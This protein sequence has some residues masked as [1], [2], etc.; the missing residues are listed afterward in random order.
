MQ[1]AGV[2]IRDTLAAH[3][4]R[5]Q[6]AGICKGPMID[7]NALLESVLDSLPDGLAVLD[8]RDSV[9]FWNAEAE[10]ITGYV[11]SEIQTSKQLPGLARLLERSQQNASSG[12]PSSAT[13]V[14]AR[15]KL[16]HEVLV[17]VRSVE[18][19]NVEGAVLGTAVLFHPSQRLDEL[20]CGET[21]DEA[22]IATGQAEFK[23][24]L[25]AEFDDFERGEQSFGILWISVD[26]GYDL[27]RTH[28]VAACHAML[29]K[30]QHAIASGLRPAETLARWGEDEFLVLGHERSA[31]ML[32]RHACTLAGLA[33]TADFRWW[34]DRVS[35]TVSIGAAQA[36]FKQPL[37][38]LLEQARTAMEAS[39]RVGGNRVT[40]APSEPDGN[41]SD[42]EESICTPS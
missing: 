9:T 7:R 2:Q 5:I 25:Y 10:A 20:L 33:R 12:Q 23:E 13:L 37:N 30:V 34:G 24:R 39:M 6:A 11:R 28:G 3:Y 35:L 19:R 1:S 31:E 42:G 32:A 38:N 8:G 17:I 16:G 18:L 26:Q 4:A 41:L 40:C 15:H 14:R 21:E 22:T 29:E 27:R 36:G